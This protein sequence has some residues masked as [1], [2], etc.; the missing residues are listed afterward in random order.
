MSNEN[1]YI[2]EQISKF[3]N[4]TEKDND[5]IKILIAGIIED[6]QWDSSIRKEAEKICKEYLQE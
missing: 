6:S 2:E 3:Y 1:S 4:L 5:K